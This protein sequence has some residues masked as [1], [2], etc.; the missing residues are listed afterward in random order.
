MIVK[1]KSAVKPGLNRAM[2]SRQRN[3]LILAALPIIQIFIFAYL[4]MFGL[5][6][7][8]KDY[9]FDTGIWGSKW[10]GLDNFKFFLTSK[11]F[12][13]IAWNTIFLN[14]LFIIVGMIAA[15]FVA[16]LLFELVGR[17]NTKIYQTVMITPN[18]LSWVIVGYMAYA[19]LNPEAGFING[20]LQKLGL[21]K[22]NWY[23]EPGYWPAILTIV[24][25]WKGVGM[26]SVYYY[27]NLMGI[28]SSLFEAAEIDGAS[29]LQKT[30]YITVPCLKKL[31]IMLFI[32]SVGGIF[33]SDF[34]LFY[35]VTRDVGT[36]YKTTD[37][38]DT[39]IFRA[40]KTVGDMSMSSAAGFL[41]SIV[42]FITV[43]ITNAVVKRLDED[44]AMF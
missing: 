42:G 6:I 27:A 22:I 26:N 23:S 7:A 29:K 44:C 4:P 43:I 17:T 21:Q 35:Q 9:R 34:G 18:F 39:Y 8:F 31:A 38:M 3:M 40:L 19:F 16:V 25:V 12:T 14:F 11:E 2:K 36:L 15:I 28:D 5:V 20:L 41:Q 32:M 24:S 33:R 30:R 1:K 13:S 37:V 10:V